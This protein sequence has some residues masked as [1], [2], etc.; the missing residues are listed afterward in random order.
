[1]H[2]WFLCLFL[3]TMIHIL[4]KKLKIPINSLH[5]HK[6]IGNSIRTYLVHEDERSLVNII[7]ISEL[8]VG[9][10]STANLTPA[11]PQIIVPQFVTARQLLH[12]PLVDHVEAA[13]GAIFLE[14]D[15]AQPCF[16]SVGIPQNVFFVRKIFIRLRGKG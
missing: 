16:D 9:W 8:W 14:I 10:T 2:S 11:C 15:V 5:Q 3:E 7:H 13:F 1:M 12:R 6:E 4:W